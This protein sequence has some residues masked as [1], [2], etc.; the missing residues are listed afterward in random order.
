MNEW[1]FAFGV[2]E[3]HITAILDKCAG[4]KDSLICAISMQ[5]NGKALRTHDVAVHDS[6][7]QRTHH[8]DVR[9]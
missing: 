5:C 1:K 2:R 8:H 3:C 4:I 9:K 7:K 6:N